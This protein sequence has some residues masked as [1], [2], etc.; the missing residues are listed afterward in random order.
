MEEQGSGW[1][2]EKREKGRRSYGEGRVADKGTTDQRDAR[3]PISD[4]SLFHTLACIAKF[5]QSQGQVM[6]VMWSWLSAKGA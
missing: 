1:G 3:R 2:E 5:I 4:A 6:D